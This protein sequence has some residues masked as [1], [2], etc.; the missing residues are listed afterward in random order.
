MKFLEEMGGV[1]DA[2]ADAALRDGLMA[3][4]AQLAA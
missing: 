2:N 4:L 1:S 3:S